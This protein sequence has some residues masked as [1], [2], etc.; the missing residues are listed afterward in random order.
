MILLSAVA[1][2]LGVASHVLY[3]NRGEH[4]LW[5]PTYLQLFTASVIGS[6]VA[7]TKYSEFPLSTAVSITSTVAASYLFGVYTS[8]IIY[9]VW[10][11]PLNKFPGP[12]QAKIAG[13]WLT[14][15]MLKHDGY[16]KF[17]ALHKKY[18]KYV[19]IGPNDLSITDADVHEA[20]FGHNTKFRKAFW[21]D[22]A[23][24]FD[25]MHT[26]RDKAVHDRRRRIWA[27]AFSDKALRDYEPKVKIFNDKL[28][29]RIKEH[30]TG[31]INASKWF[32][33]YAFDV[34]GRL[35]FGRDYGML[36]SG[37]RH[38]ALDLLVE[39]MEAAPSRL[40]VWFFR[41]LVNI[42]FAAQGVFKFLK[43]CRDELEWRIN[44]KDE[45]GDITG[46][47][48]KGYNGMQN[49]ADDPMFQGDSRLIVVAGS[50]TTAATMT[51]LF[52]E[53]ARKP[54]EV[55]KLRDELRPLTTN[56]DWGDLDIK[57]APHLNGAINE[58]LRL[59]PPVPSGVERLVPDGGAQV[60]D[61]FLPAHTQFWMPQYV[62]GRGE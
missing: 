36:D 16:L 22:N 37:E 54:E 39:G 15:Q 59:H 42:P 26:T 35:A 28:V 7:L 17:A 10:L 47:L 41:I 55:K 19:R 38:W 32:N 20:A 3:F 6:V 60:G 27:P 50:D 62:I 46:W 58:S 51:F 13:V 2:V 31:P 56:P 61:V 25:S 11:S 8:L 29:E 52:Y 23:K 48:L 45:G 34:M 57:N 24:P 21:Y 44:N 5:S 9:R 40:P 53:L 33:L 18:G 12:W 30:G 49:P 43:F 1:A 14:S 4:H